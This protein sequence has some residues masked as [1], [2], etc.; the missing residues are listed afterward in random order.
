MLKAAFEGDSFYAESSNQACD[1]GSYVLGRKELAEP[2]VNGDFVAAMGV[3]RD[4]RAASLLYRYIP[5]I[6]NGVAKYIVLSP[7]GKMK[8]DPDVLIILAT[9]NQTEILLRAASYELGQMWHSRY[10]K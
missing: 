1:A 9:T 10:S 8:C 2:Y 6:A 7:L 3:F 5:R 4:A